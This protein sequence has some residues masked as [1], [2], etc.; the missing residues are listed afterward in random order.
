[1][2][3]IDCKYILLENSQTLMPSIITFSDRVGVYNLLADVPHVQ[4]VAIEESTGQCRVPIQQVVTTLDR[5]VV[6][7]GPNRQRILRA[8]DS[9]VQRKTQKQAL[10]TVLQSFVELV[11]QNHC[12]H[13]ILSFRCMIFLHQIH[14]APES[15]ASKANRA[16]YR[17]D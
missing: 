6:K 12:N 17:Q 9:L 14:L 3:M 2:V 11:Q 16:P 15:K 8:V 1:M 4:Y 5:M 10:G 7:V 13:D